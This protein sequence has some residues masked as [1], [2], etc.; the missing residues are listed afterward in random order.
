MN[1]SHSVK[2]VIPFSEYID[3]ALQEQLELESDIEQQFLELSNLERCS[4]SQFSTFQHD[5]W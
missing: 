1:D 2:Y 5:Q 3:S 4:P